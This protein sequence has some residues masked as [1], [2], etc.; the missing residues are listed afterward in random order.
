MNEVAEEFSLGRQILTEL[1]GTQSLPVFAPPW[2]GF[3]AEYLPLLLPAG[4]KAFSR[5]GAR[6]FA[7]AS[8]LYYIQ[9]SLRSDRF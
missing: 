1:F 2:H 8:G 7:V 9:C 4:I 6:S 5:K 3:E